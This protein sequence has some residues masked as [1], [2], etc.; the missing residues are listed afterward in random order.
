MSWY[1]KVRYSLS[2]PTVT[3]AEYYVASKGKTL[4]KI[5]MFP[6]DILLNV[7]TDLLWKRVIWQLKELLCKS[8]NSLKLEVYKGKLGCHLSRLYY[9]FQPW[10]GV[11]LKDIWVQISPLIILSFYFNHFN[12]H[13]F[14]KS[15]SSLIFNDCLLWNCTC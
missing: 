15:V 5:W 10:E 7:R 13:V 3:N 11:W 2:F 9:E 1:P 14:M 6:G 8:M 12:C 4:F